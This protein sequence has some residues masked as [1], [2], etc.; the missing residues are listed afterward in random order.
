MLGG[1]VV[2]AEDFLEQRNRRGHA[3]D[4]KLIEHAAHTGTASRR[5]WAVTMTLP[6]IESNFGE[7]VSPCSTPVSMRTPGAAGHWIFSKVPEPGGQVGGRGL[8]W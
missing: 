4:H 6:I 5:F 8:R 2:V 7:M 1:E 3:F